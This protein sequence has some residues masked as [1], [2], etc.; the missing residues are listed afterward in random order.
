[1]LIFLE[2]EYTGLGQADP[3]LIS[4]GLVP[5]DDSVPF[6]AEIQV[7][8]GWQ[9]TDCNE[10]VIREVLPI[11]KGGKYL[12]PRKIIKTE[13]LRWLSGKPRELQVACDSVTDFRFLKEILGEDWPPKLAGAFYDLAPLIASSIYDRAAQR[14][15]TLDQPPHNALADANAHRAGWLAWA[16]ANKERKSKPKSRQYRNL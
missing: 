15:Y 14:F 2:T 5:L 16:D 10:F 1:M 3:K 11:L 7:D 9:L 4:I 6:Y 12:M 8:D 13:L